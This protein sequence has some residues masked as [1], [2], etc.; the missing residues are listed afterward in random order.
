M[1]FLDSAAKTFYHNPERARHRAVAELQQTAA[2][3]PDAPRI[4]ELVGELEVLSGDFRSL[5]AREYRYAPPYDVKR[6]HH[7]WATWSCTMRRSTSP[8]LPAGS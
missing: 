3:T 1:L 6:M 4:L 5:W 8:A 2:Q 7:S